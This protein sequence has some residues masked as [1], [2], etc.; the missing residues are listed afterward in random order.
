MLRYLLTRVDIGPRAPWSRRIRGVQVDGETKTRTRVLSADRR[1][2]AWSGA[3]LD[4]QDRPPGKVPT[5]LGL[6]AGDGVS[7]GEAVDDV[8]RRLVGGAGIEL[9]PDQVVELVEELRVELDRFIAEKLL[10]L[11]HELTTPAFVSALAL[12]TLTSGVVRPGMGEELL[13]VA[14]RSARL[15]V[16][17]IALLGRADEVHGRFEVAPV[18]ADVAGIV[19]ELLA[20]LRLVGRGHRLLLVTA[21]PLQG[22]VDPVAVRRTVTALVNNAVRYGGPTT[23]VRVRVAA[24]ADGLGQVDVSDDGPGISVEDEAEVFSRFGHLGREGTGVGLFVAR[25][26]AR[27]QGGDLVVARDCEGGATMRLTFPPVPGAGGDAAPGGAR[28][29]VSSDPAGVIGALGRL[30]AVDGS[31]PAD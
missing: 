31:A 3:A 22:L 1:G 19:A 11:R 27:A 9:S 17:T 10:V 8:V 21:G 26:L 16:D 14:A 28:P 20:E 15:V 5:G 18:E 7:M 6:T 13:Q 25:G 29:E 2:T 30:A 12:E 24:A 23:V 4:E